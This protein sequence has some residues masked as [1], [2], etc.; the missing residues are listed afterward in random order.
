MCPTLP[1]KILQDISSKIPPEKKFLDIAAP[2]RCN[3]GQ[4]AIFVKKMHFSGRKRHFFKKFILQWWNSVLIFYECTY[5]A[6]FPYLTSLST[7][8]CT[9][10]SCFVNFLPIL[11]NFAEIYKLFPSILPISTNIFPKFS[12][13]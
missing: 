2:T 13:N 9:Y 7:H 10:F 12:P 11:V 3:G 1:N 8:L 6:H 4:I 5:W